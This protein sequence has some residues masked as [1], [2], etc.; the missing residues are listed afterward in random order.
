MKLGGCWARRWWDVTVLEV[1]DD[2]TVRVHWDKLGDA[3]DGDVSRNN[4]II[5]KK[6][7]QKGSAKSSRK[8][9]NKSSASDEAS[10]AET[11]AGESRF[12]VVLK[13]FGGQRIAVTKTVADITGLDLKDAKEFVESAPVVIK[14]NLTKAKAEKIRGQLQD[15]GATVAIELQ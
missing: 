13:S 4:L 7:L 15:S 5:A 12:R 10:A 6:D 2:D 14:Q 8:L 1:N 9:A 3:W 11:T